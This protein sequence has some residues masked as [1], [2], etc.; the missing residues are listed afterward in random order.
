MARYIAK[1]IVASGVCEKCEIQLSY[2]IGVAQPTSIY[3]DCYGKQKASIETIVQTVHDNFDLS[4][5][6][7]IRTLDLKRPIYSPTAAYG[8]FGRSEF[9]WEQLNKKEIFKALIK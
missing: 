9:P 6:G 7:I 3:I 2:A 5:S 4:P 8:H 1:N